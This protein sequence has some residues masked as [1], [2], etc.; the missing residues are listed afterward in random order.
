MSTAAAPAADDYQGSQST[1]GRAL[2]W[3]FTLNNPTEEEILHLEGVSPSE[4]NTDSCIRTLFY[5]R[6][7]GESGTPHL[8][9]FVI[10]KSRQR[11]SQVKRLLGDR[12]CLFVMRGTIQQ[13]IEYCSKDGDVTRY[14]DDPATITEERARTDIQRTIQW[15]DDFISENGRA[16]TEAE[17]A[18]DHPV[19]LLQ[20]NDFMKVAR[21][22]APTVV[23]RGEEQE[24]REWQQ[25]LETLLNDP[26]EDDRKINFFVDPVGG[27]GKTFFQQWYFS[28]NPTRVQ[29]LSGGSYND[30]AYIIDENCDVFFFNIPR[31]GMEYFSYRVV[32]SLKDRIVPSTKYQGVTKI[33]SHQ[34]HVCVFCNE[35]PDMTK[36]SQ[37][38]FNIKDLSD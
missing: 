15:L 30:L 29:I 16:P 20:Y 3:V 10:F 28:K 18:A 14:G 12:L 37:D 32:E 35:T 11:F 8:Q 9:G 25:E 21:L 34:P 17:V 22:R 23:L 33:L 1:R 13:N 5:G 6:E 38:R 36:L 4:T 27:A 26:C 2:R 24:L 31:G 19:A 7:V